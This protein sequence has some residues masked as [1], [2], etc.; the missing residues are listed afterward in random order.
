MRHQLNFLIQK[1]GLPVELEAVTQDLWK[2]RILQLGRK[3]KNDSQDPGMPQTFST[4][5]S[6]TETE[7]DPFAISSRKYKIHECRRHI[8]CLSLCYLGAVTLRLPVTPGNIYTWVTEEGMPYLT[9]IRLLPPPMR[10]RLPSTYHSALSPYSLLDLRRFYTSV[11][12]IQIG[13]EQEFLIVWPPLNVPLLLFQYLKALAL[14]LE[15]YD[16]TMRLGEKLGYDFTLYATR[17]QKLSITDLPEARLMSCLVICVKLMFPFDDDEQD[18]GA[19]IVPAAT[20]IHW[21]TWCRVMQGGRRGEASIYKYTNEQLMEVKEDHVFSMTRDEVDDYL[22]FYLT[23]FQDER[24]IEEKTL[25][26]DFQRALHSMFPTILDAHVRSQ[27]SLKDEQ[28]HAKLHPVRAV[29]SAMT[30]PRST[31]SLEEQGSL[32]QEIH[33][34]D[35]SSGS[36]LPEHARHFLERAAMIAGLTVDMLFRCVQHIQRRAI[37]EQDRRAKVGMQRPVAEPSRG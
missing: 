23:N 6:E 33:Y 20:A 36:D 30:E 31:V 15:L 14:P 7:E 11:T 12:N 26:S 35:Y 22:D 17:R 2:L 34:V 29:H 24:H 9:A 32:K 8:D 37:R 13:L 1:K 21:P 28:H 27:A 3:I 25:D 16:A 4:H 10:S 5:G 18:P 19:T